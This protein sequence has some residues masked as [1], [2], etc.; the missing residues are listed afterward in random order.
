MRRALP[1]VLLLVLGAGCGKSSSS[2]APSTSTPPPTVTSAPPGATTSG[3]ET[4]EATTL[5]RVYFLRNG[6]VGPVARNVPATQTIG[7][8]ALSALGDGPTDEERAQ[9]LRTELTSTAAVTNLRIADGVATIELQDDLSHAALAQVVYTLT[10]FPT[11]ERVRP[12]RV[13]GGTKAFTRANFEDVTPSILVESPLP[14]Q[15]VTSPL[16]V[17]GTANTFEAN[18]ELA[19]R[20]SSGVT[21]SSRFVTATSG[22][23]T[24]GTYDTTISFPRT[25]GPITLVAFE[26]SAENGKPIHIVR[27]PLKEG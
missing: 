1:L 8:A 15:A 18:F 12:S 3:T 11:V 20:N 19:I 14:G 23:G 5:L 24:R 13:I 22:S 25:G 21:V 2:S 16:E 6:K 17:R 9:G 27:I 7:S 10:Q 26:P 4:S